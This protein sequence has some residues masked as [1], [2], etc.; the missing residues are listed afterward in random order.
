MKYNEWSSIRK[1]RES[2][3]YV[4][5]QDTGAYGGGFGESPVS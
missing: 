2:T 5:F 3:N 4:N 1:E